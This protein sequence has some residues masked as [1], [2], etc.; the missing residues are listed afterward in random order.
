MSND[1]NDQKKISAVI[2]LKKN[3]KVDAAKILIRNR[4]KRFEI[5]TL[6]NKRN[7]V[8]SEGDHSVIK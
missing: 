3:I 2:A 5:P 1:Q 7:P 8:D 4:L 6:I